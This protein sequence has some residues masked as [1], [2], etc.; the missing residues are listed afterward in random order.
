MIGIFEVFVLKLIDNALSTLKT[1]YMHKEKFFLSGVFNAFSTF[2][3]LIAIVEIA[4]SNNI[5]SI[6]SMCVGTFVGTYLPGI[7]VKKSEGDKLF[8]FDITADELDA[9]KDFAD[10]LRDNN[11]AIK[12]Y[13]SYDSDMKKVLS[14]KTYCNT[15]NESK[16]VSSLIPKSFNHNVYVPLD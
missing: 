15:R 4:K 11:I 1:V 14:C 9:G 12:T 7:V 2:F 10:K 5:F 13:I 6:V 3:Y 16:I 8:I